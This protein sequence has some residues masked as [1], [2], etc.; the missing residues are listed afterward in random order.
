MRLDEGQVDPGEIDI[1]G[2]VAA[3][4]IGLQGDLVGEVYS[5]ISFW[6]IPLH[7]LF[8]SMG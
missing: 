8:S 6:W 3:Y 5:D 1:G 7:Y 4:W 2:L